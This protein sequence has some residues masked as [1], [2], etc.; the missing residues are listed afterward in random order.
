MGDSGKRGSEMLATASRTI[1]DLHMVPGVNLDPLILSLRQA[2]V[3]LSKRL[4]ESDA[5]TA[6]APVVLWGCRSGSTWIF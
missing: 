3:R 4:A 1:L 5:A 6:A 2:K